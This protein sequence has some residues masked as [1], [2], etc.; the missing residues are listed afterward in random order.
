MGTCGSTNGRAAGITRLPCEIMAQLS[1]GSS[2]LVRWRPGGGLIFSAQRGG[3]MTP[4]PPKLVIKCCFASNAIFPAQ[5]R[6]RTVSFPQKNAPPF[7]QEVMITM[8]RPSKRRAFLLFMEFLVCV[9]IQLMIMPHCNHLS[10]LPGCTR[11]ILVE[12]IKIHLRPLS[13]PQRPRRGAI[14]IE[15]ESDI[16]GTHRENMGGF[17]WGALHV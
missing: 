17:V 15:S 5:G 3:K 8:W 10:G 6:T 11:F 1:C 9:N 14:T 7:W 16:S 13:L 4:I 12:A 2:Y